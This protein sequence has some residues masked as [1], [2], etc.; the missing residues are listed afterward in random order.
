MQEL[1]RTDPIMNANVCARA[2][3]YRSHPE[4]HKSYLSMNWM[5]QTTY[6]RGTYMFPQVGKMVK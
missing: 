5:V 2:V 6:I 4:N 3:S 1:C